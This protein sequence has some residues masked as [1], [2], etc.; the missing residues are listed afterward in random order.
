MDQYAPGI[1]FS[2]HMGSE[3]DPSRIRALVQKYYHMPFTNQPTLLNALILNHQINQANLG[4]SDI[5]FSEDH[6]RNLDFLSK[7]NKEIFTNAVVLFGKFRGLNENQL[8]EILAPCL[9]PNEESRTRMRNVLIRLMCYDKSLQNQVNFDQLFDSFLETHAEELQLES[10]PYC[11]PDQ[12]DQ[13]RHLMFWHYIT[14]FSVEQMNRFK[15]LRFQKLQLCYRI[16]PA[17]FIHYLACIFCAGD[18]E[19]CLDVAHFEANLRGNELVMDIWSLFKIKSNGGSSIHFLEQIA[20]GVD[21]VTNDPINIDHRDFDHCEDFYKPEVAE[22]VF[23]AVET[24]PVLLYEMKIYE[25]FHCST[26]RSYD[27]NPSPRNIVGGETPEKKLG[28]HSLLI[29]G[30]RRVAIF[31]ESNKFKYYFLLQNWWSGQP[32]VEVSAMYLFNCGAKALIMRTDSPIR[33]SGYRGGMPTNTFHV[34][35]T[36]DGPD[37][38]T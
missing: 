36:C 7:P 38:D 33:I 2:F 16:A 25:G 37:K 18:F 15:I 9:K 30:G 31:G 21:S 12:T 27:Y 19:D 17:V 23:R 1:N 4:L 5:R 34:A 28:L 32:F 3:T 11:C 6:L 8:V 22:A 35:E 13:N 26:R 24:Q 20:Q 10:S 14:V 29:I